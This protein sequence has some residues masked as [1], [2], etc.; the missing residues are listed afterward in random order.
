[1]Q[2]PLIGMNRWVLQKGVESGEVHID[3][4]LRFYGRYSRALLQFLIY[5][6]DPYI[7]MISYNEER[8]QKLL[9]NLS[10]NPSA[11]GKWSTYSQLNPEQK[12]QLISELANILLKSNMVKKAG[13]LISE[14]YVFPKHK[15]DETYEANEFSTLLNACGRHNRSDIGLRVCLGDESAY[16]EARSLLTLHRKMIKEGIS[17]A[18]SNIQDLGPFFFLDARCVIDE[19]I[20]GTVCGMVQRATWEKPIIG[21]SLGEDD[22]LKF[23]SRTNRA[24]IEAGLNLGNLM[25]AGVQ[26]SGG[27]GG[28]HKI[29]AGASIP[30]DKINE[31][32]LAIGQELRGST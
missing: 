31:F 14:S 30:K 22:T 28:G 11:E 23:S 29:A 10:I 4:D 9:T 18:S 19:S 6:D 26:A 27:I 20:L 13:E 25:N 8:A 21:V 2:S 32:L 7:P 12:K 16:T 5:S 15:K 3:N 24:L 1:M 17:F